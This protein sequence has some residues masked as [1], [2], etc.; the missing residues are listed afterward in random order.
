MLNSILNTLFGV[1]NQ[2]RSGTGCKCPNCGAM[3]DKA[4]KRKTKC[5][6]C[7][8]DVYV[9]N[10]QSIFP[11]VFLTQKDAMAVDWLKRL[12]DYGLDEADYFSMNS[13]LAK[14]F[15][16]QPFSTDVIWGLFSKL[17]LLN[18]KD[19]QFIGS[20]RYSM[21]LFLYQ[22][23]RDFFPELQESARMELMSFRKDSI[24]KAEIHTCKEAS[25][26]ACRALDGTVLTVK[27]A[28]KLMPIPC[29]DCTHSLGKNNRGFCRCRYL[30]HFE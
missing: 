16:R 21:A 26:E 9:R 28:L 20:L 6:S 14:R 5:V 22:E 29:N 13:E 11:S 8:K 17:I 7:N 12:R 25:C 3:I 23:G 2:N 27:D 10:K 15:G 30:A 1:K 18:S 19:F 24:K 4:P